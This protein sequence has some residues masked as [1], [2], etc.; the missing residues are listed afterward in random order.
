MSDLSAL[1]RETLDA[2][3][4]APDESALEATRVAALGK[5][6]TISALLATLGKLAP[7]E[8]KF[9]GAAINALKDQVSGALAAR[10]ALLKRAAL[11][12]QLNRETLDVTLPVPLPGVETGRIHPISQVMDEI[13][14]IFAEMG[15]SVAEGPDIESDDYNF[16]SSTSRP[17]IRRVRCTTRSFSNPTSMASASF[18]APTR[19]RCRCARC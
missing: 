7:D 9:Q 17:A 6:G 16:T 10:R 14:T 8:R 13:T 18:C 5:K 1:E 3:A 12:T 2:I 11:E 4:G 19:A 15:F